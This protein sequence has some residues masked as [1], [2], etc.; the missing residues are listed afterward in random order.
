MSV[1]VHLSK[2]DQGTCGHDVLDVLARDAAVPR[3]LLPEALR[4]LRL[5]LLLGREHGARP[6]PRRQP[7]RLEQAFL[8]G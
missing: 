5:R 8:L 2:S 4:P 7:I 1:F 3:Q 6:R